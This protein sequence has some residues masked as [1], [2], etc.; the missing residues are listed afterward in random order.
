VGIRDRRAAYVPLRCSA[1]RSTDPGPR[2]RLPRLR[3]AVLQALGA[4]LIWGVS[5]LALRTALESAAPL[6]VV[7]MRNAFGAALLFAIL[8][9][10]GGKVLPEREDWRRAG[11]LGALM[12]AHM[13]IQTHSMRFT[14]TMRAGWIVAFIPVV[15]AVGARLF[16]KQRM[17]AIGWLGIAVATSGVFVLTSTRPESLS[18]AGAGDALM[19]AS[20]FTWA[21]YSLTALKAVQRSGGLRISAAAL[22]LSVLPTGSAAAFGESWHSE[23]TLRSA[24]ALLFLGAGASAVAM[25]LF[26]N[27]LAVLGPERVAA[28]QY[29]QP[30][31]TIAASF[32]FLSEPFTAAQFLGG[33]IVLVG[34]WLVQRG[35]RDVG[36]APSST[37]P[38]RRDA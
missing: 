33:P 37:P 15:V 4:T 22:A 34:V 8:R 18:E 9:A 11:V 2:R 30:F 12:G 29:L 26:S 20:T 28:F 21:A 19:L 24:S 23:P 35:K 10:R 25:W 32:A 1:R 5:F 27:A 31:V 36:A 16:L 17:R 38:L 7:W 13:L 14:T 3:K 6:G